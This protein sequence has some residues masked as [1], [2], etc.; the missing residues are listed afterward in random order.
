M[1]LHPG[2]V[3]RL[4]E[5]IS[6]VT[7]DDDDDK[8]PPSA[9]TFCLITDIGTAGV[10]FLNKIKYGDNPSL[11]I[12]LWAL[13][14]EFKDFFS[15]SLPEPAKLPYFSID[16]PL[17]NC[18]VPFA[19]QGLESSLEHRKQKLTRFTHVI[20]NNPT[21]RSNIILPSTVDIQTAHR[22]AFLHRL[23]KTERFN[24]NREDRISQRAILCSHGFYSWLPSLSPRGVSHS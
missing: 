12:R 5:L 22:V 18:E 14:S 6:F 4:D 15:T 16:V 19:T 21:I 8:I 1:T 3:R 13:C 2:E 10:N 7:A 24:R 17:A 11:N 23:Q 9:D 20:R